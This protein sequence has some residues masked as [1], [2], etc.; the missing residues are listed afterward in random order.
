[1][2][3]IVDPIYEH[4]ITYYD[5][6]GFITLPDSTKKVPPHEDYRGAV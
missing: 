6:L 5:K 2:A 1:M 3:V 4:A